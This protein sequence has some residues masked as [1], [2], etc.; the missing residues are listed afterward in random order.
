MNDK[1]TGLTPLTVKGYNFIKANKGTTLAKLAKGIDCSD[2]SSAR[3]KVDLLSRNLIFSN[4]GVS[5][6]KRGR[7]T[8]TLTAYASK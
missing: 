4:E 6:G 8:I 3:I 5:T 2:R 1:L 7:P